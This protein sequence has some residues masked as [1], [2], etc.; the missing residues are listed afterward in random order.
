[1]LFS[2]YFSCRSSALLGLPRRLSRL[3]K[4]GGRPRSGLSAGRPSAYLPCW[5]RSQLPRRVLQIVEGLMWAL[6]LCQTNNISAFVCICNLQP[7]LKKKVHNETDSEK[8]KSS[9]NNIS[10]C[11]FW[12]VLVMD[13]GSCDSL[14]FF[15]MLHIH[16][17]A[18]TVAGFKRSFMT[19]STS[20]HDLQ[21]PRWKHAKN[22]RLVGVKSTSY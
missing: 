2:R 4:S 21:Q 5:H 10:P 15:S 11:A 12:L 9:T 6:L 16:D 14:W 18:A 22:W 3:G 8:K 20:H 19:N 7:F 1:M 17:V 13:G